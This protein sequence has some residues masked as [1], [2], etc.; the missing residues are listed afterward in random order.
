MKS[1][2]LG[3]A[4]FA[5]TLGAVAYYPSLMA[6]NME[7]TPPIG[8]MIV[9]Q[10]PKIDV[11]F[12]LD[13]TGSMS[14]LIETAKEKIWSIAT[15]MASAQP[16]PEIRIGLVRNCGASLLRQGAGLSGRG[17]PERATTPCRRRG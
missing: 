6:K 15:T 7:A 1:K 16:T 2:L 4:L 9:Q 14:G 12:V 3:I 8:H 5:I 11:V 13:T 17:A 10:H